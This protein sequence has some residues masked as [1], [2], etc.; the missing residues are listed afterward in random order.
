MTLR[1]GAYLDKINCSQ[2]AFQN[3]FHLNITLLIW[4][5]VIKQYAHSP[6]PLFAP[7]MITTF[8][9]IF[10]SFKMSIAVLNVSTFTL[11]FTLGLLAKAIS[12][13]MY[14]VRPFIELKFEIK[15]GS[16]SLY[17]AEGESSTALVQKCQ[18]NYYG[19]HSNTI[20]TNIEKGL[21]AQKLE[22]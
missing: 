11:P 15:S 5:S 1:T 10:L 14:V 20:F 18:V 9:D 16:I 17:I 4:H 3:A 8:P 22:S 21:I 7:V 19:S 12:G 6:M 13:S 2:M